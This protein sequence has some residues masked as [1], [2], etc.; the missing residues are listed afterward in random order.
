[1]GSRVGPRLPSWPTSARS[2]H[3]GLSWHQTWGWKASVSENSR[4]CGAAP[5]AHASAPEACCAPS[6]GSVFCIP[7]GGSDTVSAGSLWPVHALCGSVSGLRECHR[8]CML[9]GAGC[10]ERTGP[11]GKATQDT[12]QTRT[13]GTVPTCPRLEHKGESPGQEPA[14]GA[15][16]LPSFPSGEGASCLSVPQKG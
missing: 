15:R 7:A 4:S 11:S 12:R 13:A 16:E 6:S 10:G 8:G 2:L 3:S 5:S 9:E 1:M 14:L